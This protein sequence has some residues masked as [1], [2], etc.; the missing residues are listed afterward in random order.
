M[1]IV[2]NGA[3]TLK[4]QIEET[5]MTYD[6]HPYLIREGEYVYNAVT[7]DVVRNIDPEQDRAELISRWFM[8]PTDV[9]IDGMLY[10][11][12]QSRIFNTARIANEYTIFTTMRCNAA[13][14]YCFQHGGTNESMSEQMAEKVAEYILNR[15]DVSRRI[16]LRWFGGEPLM[17]KGPIN[18]ICKYLRH[19]GVNFRSNMSTNGDLFP[20]VGDGELYLWNLSTVQLT[21]DYPDD[22]YARIK[23]LPEGAYERLKE[24]LHRFETLGVHAN[25]RVHYHPESGL[26]PA[27]KIVEDFKNFS[28][29]YMYAA[30][31][32]DEPRT[33]E[34]Y[35]NLYLLEDKMIEAGVL[36]FDIGGAD[37]VTY[38]MAD[39]L[40]S[41]CIRVDGTLTPCEHYS[42]G[43]T[44]GTIFDSDSEID[45][46]MLKKW[47]SKR[48]YRDHCT[49]CPL[50]PT[51]E[52]LTNC[53]SCGVCEDGYKDY[54]IDRIK[55]VLK[56]MG[57]SQ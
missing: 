40:H 27:F 17:N 5:H 52:I 15:S 30:M 47:R 19:R 37:K 34:D 41:K 12:R 10:F 53:P 14:E 31:I 3:N 43:E 49:D 20:E 45:Y 55:R 57:G 9:D 51:C 21:I 8:V 23:G 13:C 22:E 29:I 18:V 2:K 11:N 6:F 56:S 48:K 36:R 39:N 46:E 7:G 42:T 54:R 44:S 28:N 38:C 50:Y 4:N 26:E 32:Y 1:E 24:T 16:T 33:P 25:I 35:Y